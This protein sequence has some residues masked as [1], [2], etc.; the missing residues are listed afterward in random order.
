MK[1]DGAALLIS[2][3]RLSQIFRWPSATVRPQIHVR[4]DHLPLPPAGA[5]VIRPVS[6]SFG[7]RLATGEIRAAR[8]GV[9]AERSGVGSAD[10]AEGG[11][12]ETS[13]W[14]RLCLQR[15]VRNSSAKPGLVLIQLKRCYECYSWYFW[16][17]VC[18]D[19]EDTNV[20]LPAQATY[21]RTAGAYIV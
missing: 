17:R 9:G 16:R 1:C 6:T 5:A 14:E 10:A 12:L 13:E 19:L 8:A 15:S 2:Y 3:C 20:M 7:G 11:R 4:T 18:C 21:H